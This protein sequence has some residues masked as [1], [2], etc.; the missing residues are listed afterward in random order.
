MSFEIENGILK[1]IIDEG[2]SVTIPEGVT[3]FGYGVFR[4]AKIK[5]I[6]I[7]GSVEI[8]P[9]FAFQFCYCLQHVSLGEG[10]RAIDTYAF[11]HC[12]NLEAVDV[13]STLTTIARGAFQDCG[14][15]KELNFDRRM[16]FGQN[17]FMG[18]DSL[19]ISIKLDSL[20]MRKTLSEIFDEYNPIKALNLTVGTNSFVPGCTKYPPG[21]STF[22]LPIRTLRISEGV[23]TL[24]IEGFMGKGFTDLYLPCTIREIVGSSF[25]RIN[26][27]NVYIQN[28]S[29]FMNIDY[30]YEDDQPMQ[31]GSDLYLNNEKLTKFII[32]EDITEIKPY[33]FCGCSS[34]EKVVL[35][36]GVTAIGNGAF[37]NCKNLVDIEIPNS[38]SSIGENAFS[39]CEKLESIS[40]PNSITKLGRYTF[41]EC[42]S[43]KSI[44]IPKKV[45]AIGEYAFAECEKLLKAVIPEHAANIGV[46]A[47][48]HCP[49][50]SEVKLPTSATMQDLI[51]DKGRD[52][53]FMTYSKND[54][55]YK[56]TTLVSCPN[57][58]KSVRI[59]EGTK[60]I[61]DY[62]FKNCSYL[63]EIVIPE[64]VEKLGSYVFYKCENLKK[65]NI[66]RSLKEVSFDTF[67]EIVGKIWKD[68]YQTYA[69]P[70]EIV[71]DNKHKEAIKTLI[72]AGNGYRIEYGAG[73]TVARMI[74][75]DSYDWQHGA[76][77]Y[78][79]NTNGRRR[80]LFT[81][82]S[83]H[84]VSYS[85]HESGQDISEDFY[86]FS[87]LEIPENIP[88]SEAVLYAC[89]NIDKWKKTD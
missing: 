80:F 44:E 27:S 86:S 35:H 60:E 22:R 40:L 72:K 11:S 70:P 51:F 59:K 14:K 1:G 78:L 49:S 41:Y 63:K 83:S 7:P 66:P 88:D 74:D 18:C 55:V 71:G 32:P 46:N 8:V 87:E 34:I 30:S 13:P 16:Y 23:E 81:G 28:L 26:V 39:G 33:A 24:H 62:A 36:K 4:H 38:L 48:L 85:D 56:G 43:L 17:A 42:K 61:A 9:S 6:S 77:V 79:E 10:V 29:A 5:E 47:F 25:W 84:T 64:G 52:I 67:N 68:N 3:S 53:T 50:L 69:P 65:I 45:T 2:E 54:C 20:D 37:K 15:L 21:A 58:A 31:N 89:E 12:N 82:T 75:F 73:G 76:S 19:E 57:I